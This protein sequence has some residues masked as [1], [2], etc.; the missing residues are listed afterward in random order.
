MPTHLI[1]MSAAANLLLKG[2]DRSALRDT[3]M[4][5]SAQTPKPRAP[6]T[7]GG[8]ICFPVALAA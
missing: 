6:P 4:Q 2:E 5:Q 7:A 3:G 8:G 1:D